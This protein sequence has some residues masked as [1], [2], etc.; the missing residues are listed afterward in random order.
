MV[1][2]TLKNIPPRL[3]ERL[4]ERARVNR[5]SLQMEIL[6]C[7]EEVLEPCRP[8]PEAVLADVREVHKLFKGEMDANEIIRIIR[9]GRQ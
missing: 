9:R 6:A 3:H 1:S 2:I 8:D 7:L 4:K 5:R